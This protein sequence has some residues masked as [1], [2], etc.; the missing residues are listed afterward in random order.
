MPKKKVKKAP[1]Y[2][3][4]GP[5]WGKTTSALGVALRAMGHG[6]KVVI[7][8]WMKG[9][10]ERIGE[11]HVRKLLG[12][13]LSKLY[14]I[15][16][17]GRKEWVNLKTPE[18]TDKALAK[19]CLELAKKKAKQKPFLLVL[20]EINLAVAIGLIS[21]K[22]LI[23]FLDEVPPSVHVYLTGRRAT[24]GLIKRA[25]YVNHIVNTKGQKKL[26]GEEGI[27]Y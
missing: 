16:Q 18:K 8:Q 27:D 3:W 4:T 20:D 21:E 19:E 11:Y 13:K 12:P 26:V 5:G 10:G 17:C 9:W 6:Y 25:D 7:L 22:E 23:K 15:E 1:V 24:P 2:L 14:D